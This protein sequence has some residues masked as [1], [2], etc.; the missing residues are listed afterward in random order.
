MMDDRFFL[1]DTKAAGTLTR[2]HLFPETAEVLFIAATAIIT[3]AVQAA[4]PQL[5]PRFHRHGT[6]SSAARSFR[7]SR[8][9][10]SRQDM[11]PGER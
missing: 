9:P 1:L 11:N 7:V 10:G 3:G 6:P 8:F 2:Q 4:H 5:A